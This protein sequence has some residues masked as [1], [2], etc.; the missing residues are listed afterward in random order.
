MG[1]I[2]KEFEKSIKAFT[3]F[4]KQLTEELKEKDK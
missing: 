4:L 2:K 3:D 1:S